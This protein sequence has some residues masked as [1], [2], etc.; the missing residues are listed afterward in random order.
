L[1]RC[2]YFFTGTASPP[3]WPSSPT[4]YPYHEAQPA[5]GYTPFATPMSKEE[6]LNYLN[7]QA[8][9]IKDELEQIESRV[10][11]LESED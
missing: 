6:E 1:P 5:A 11:D 8:E 2:G 3:A 9:A 7:E 4:P 10:R